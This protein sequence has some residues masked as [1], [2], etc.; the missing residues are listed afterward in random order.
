LFSLDSARD[1]FFSMKYEDS[2]ELLIKEGLGGT[3]ISS[4]ELK[5]VEW[6]F[7]SE[8]CFPREHL[9]QRREKLCPGLRKWYLAVRKIGVPAA[10][11]TQ[12]YLK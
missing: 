7:A 12:T 5:R 2:Y 4:I 9:W 8:V 10:A 6:R 1:W 3:K 11:V